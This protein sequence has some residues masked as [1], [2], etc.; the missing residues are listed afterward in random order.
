MWLAHVLGALGKEITK[1]GMVSGFYRM[2]GLIGKSDTECK[3]CNCNEEKC[4]VS[5]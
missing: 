5:M 2:H 3:L 4:L 1:T